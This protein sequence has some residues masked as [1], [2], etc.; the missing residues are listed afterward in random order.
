MVTLEKQLTAD[1]FWEKYAGQRVE[2]VRGKPVEMTP[3]SDL[4][5]SGHESDLHGKVANLI[6]L[7]MTAHVMEHD[8]GEVR[9]AE[10]GFYLGRD[11][12]V[13]RAADA[14]FI[15]KDRARDIDDPDRFTPFPPDLAV[16]VVSFDDLAG[17][18]QAKISDY[19]AAGVRLMWIIYPQQKQVAVYRP[20]GTGETLGVGDTL[21]GGD[22]LPGF[23]L[24]LAKLFPGE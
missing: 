15:G 16:E 2:L 24:P 11:P 14:A 9:A 5:E 21:T 13:V 3:T 12:D 4:H 18:T 10:T 17:E 19:L 6:A 23:A 8:L 7:Y 20:D 1:E 22:V